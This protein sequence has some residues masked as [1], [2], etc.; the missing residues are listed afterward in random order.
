[1]PIEEM[2]QLF[3]APHAQELDEEKQKDVEFRVENLEDAKGVR[4]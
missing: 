3:G 1:M 4:R 2:D